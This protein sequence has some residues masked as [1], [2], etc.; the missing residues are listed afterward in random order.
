[1]AMTISPVTPNFAAE[2]GDVDLSQPLTAA[3]V[4][5]IKQAFW[6]YAPSSSFLVRS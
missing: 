6:R 2:I 5:E 1:M 3:E 4:D